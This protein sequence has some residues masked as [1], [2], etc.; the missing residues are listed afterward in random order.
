MILLL[1]FLNSD[2]RIRLL[3]I[4]L[5]SVVLQVLRVTTES[6]GSQNLL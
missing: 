5:F 6:E 4:L 2:L 3:L 1:K